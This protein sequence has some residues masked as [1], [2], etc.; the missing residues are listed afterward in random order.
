MLDRSSSVSVDLDRDAP[1]RISYNHPWPVGMLEDRV[2]YIS[3]V[4]QTVV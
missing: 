2:G 4:G 3:A 1:K